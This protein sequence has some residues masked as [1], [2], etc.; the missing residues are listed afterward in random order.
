MER[1]QFTAAL[2]GSLAA[3]V[4]L[5]AF[6]LSQGDAAA[7][8]RAALERGA[9]AAVDLLGRSDGFLGNPKVRIG[10]PGFLEDEAKLLKYT[11][12]SHRV[13]ELETAMNRAA[14]AAVPQAKSMLVSA[15]KSVTVE[16]A[17]RIVRGNDT[18][19]TDYFSS[20]TR[21]PL[22][23]QFL[24]IVTRATEQVALT[25]RYNA[26]AGRIASFGLLKERDANIEQYV[27]AKALDGL[28][29]MIGEEER[30]IRADPLK[31][32]SDLLRRVFGR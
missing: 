5:P 13:E 18:S 27:T 17:L 28:F 25:D 16:D 12:Q 30:K 24:P 2:M 22:S 10:L 26:V 23:V 32:G 11:G 7:G 29:L 14:E 21:E 15:A 20:R 9:I 6:A 1:R 19:V 31:T 8:I 4:A 3:G